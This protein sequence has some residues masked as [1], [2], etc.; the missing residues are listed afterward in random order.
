MLREH[1]VH[2]AAGIAVMLSKCWIDRA[3]DERRLETL[4]AAWK[5][6][7]SMTS[8][9]YVNALT[10]D[11]RARVAGN[12]GGNYRRLQQVKRTYDPANQFD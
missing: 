7:E 10:D 5:H 9:L 1:V 3:E 12:Y 8:S 11:E 4:R 6:I 2:E